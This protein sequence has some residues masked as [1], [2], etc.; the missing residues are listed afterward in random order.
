MSLIYW[1]WQFA[2]GINDTSGTRGTFTA[3][4]VDTDGE[5]ATGSV[6]NNE[7]FAAGV[8]DTSG[9]FATGIDDTGGAPWLVNISV[10]FQ[11]IRNGPNVIFRG[12]GKMIYEK[13]LKQKISWH[14][15]FK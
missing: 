4:V 1:W 12:L 13:N 6:D 2:T 5:F 8:V 10:N 7:K 3:S 15:P 9:S 14:C 11:K